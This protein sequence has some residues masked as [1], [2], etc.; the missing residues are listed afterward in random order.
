MSQVANVG[1]PSKALR[2]SAGKRVIALLLS[3]VKTKE[4]DIPKHSE[5][6]TLVELIGN[7]YD[8][9]TTAM[10]NPTLAAMQAEALREQEVEL[11]RREQVRKDAAAAGKNPPGRRPKNAQ[12]PVA[13]SPA[14]A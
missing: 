11:A 7:E 9:D 4:A 13:E 2:Q 14:S 10:R 6:C 3:V 12:V 5:L 8:L 1:R